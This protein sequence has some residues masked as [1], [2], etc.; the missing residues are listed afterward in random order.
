MTEPER[1]AVASNST[2]VTRAKTVCERMQKVLAKHP[3]NDELPQEAG[4]V[5]CFVV[6]FTHRS[7]ALRYEVIVVAEGKEG[8]VKTW[9]VQL[10]EWLRFETACNCRSR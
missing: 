9:V 8:A 2:A 3:F 10:A 7:Q 4:T 1:L 6:L 5:R